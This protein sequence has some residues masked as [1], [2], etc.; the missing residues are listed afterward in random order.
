MKKTVYLSLAMAAVALI[1]L[2]IA[3]VMYRNRTQNPSREGRLKKI[4]AELEMTA[5]EIKKQKLEAFNAQEQ[6]GRLMRSEWQAYIQKV[7]E[8][9]AHQQAIKALEQQQRTLINEKIK[10]EKQ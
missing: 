7:K 5:A 3:L 6:A 10:L 1:L 8:V 4:N 2:S 9:D